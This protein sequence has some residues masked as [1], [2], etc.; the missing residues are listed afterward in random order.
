MTLAVKL[1]S[2]NQ[3]R[4]WGDGEQL[5]NSIECQEEKMGPLGTWAFH[6]RRRCL[7]LWSQGFRKHQS[8]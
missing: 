8:S 6:L 2:W 1:L 4:T 3:V 7:M 5:V